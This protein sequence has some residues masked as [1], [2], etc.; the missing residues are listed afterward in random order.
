VG[1][2]KERGG[3]GGKKK[4]SITLDA[5]LTLP[6]GEEKKAVVAAI[7]N[8]N[9]TPNLPLGKEKGEK[10]GGKG[11]SPQRRAS[12]SGPYI[13]IQ[14]DGKEGK[15]KKKAR[16]NFPC[17]SRRRQEKKALAYRRARGSL[18]RSP[19]AKKKTIQ[20][21]KKKGRVRKR[22]RALCGTTI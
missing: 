12:Q 13:F 21:K 3:G 8:T 2:R 22:K 18:N 4:N 15:K 17:D 20:R 6:S 1:H 5:H 19:P 9:I 7:I 16:V 14:V 11:R 10:G